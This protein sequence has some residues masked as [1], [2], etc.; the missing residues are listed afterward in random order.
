MFR[1]ESLL[2]A[3]PGLISVSPRP[4][5]PFYRV[6]CSERQNPVRI[7]G[8]DIGS[9]R[10]GVAISD[11]LG[12]TAQGMETILCKN[13]DADMAKIAQIVQDFH[14]TEIVVGMPYNMNG[15]E[16]P[17]AQK[18]RAVMHRIQEETQT[19]VRE[20]DERL[21]TAAAD[22]ALLE[23]DMSR[24]KRRKVV[25]KIA[26]VLILQGYLDSLRYKEFS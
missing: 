1:T 14:V 26:A 21:T 20:W 25:D 23:A 8:L 7:L 2:T 15:T 5:R 10:I 13:P 19:P 18:V 11:E 6:T 17:Q 16:G 3:V 24:A 4:V 22:R 9:K 12:F